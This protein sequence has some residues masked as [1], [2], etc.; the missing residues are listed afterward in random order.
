MPPHIAIKR[1]IFHVIVGCA[2]ISIKDPVVKP[3][4]EPR[5][6]ALGVGV[7]HKKANE[8]GDEHGQIIPVALKKQ[9]AFYGYRIAMSRKAQTVVTKACLCRVIL[10]MVCM[11]N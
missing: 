8:Y 10:Q 5:G 4:D 7:Y 2:R 11:H 9:K 3:I 1:N 6:L